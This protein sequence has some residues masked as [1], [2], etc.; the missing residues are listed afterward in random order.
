VGLTAVFAI[1]ATHDYLSW[2]RARWAAVQRALDT[3]VAPAE[4]DAGF[5]YRGRQGLPLDAG[6]PLPYRLTFTPIAGYRTVQS[7]A[8][9]RLLCTT[10]ASIQLLRK[11]GGS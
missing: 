5:E 6:P 8:V 3:G 11:D 9:R 7:F 1:A 4:L 10:P 2:N